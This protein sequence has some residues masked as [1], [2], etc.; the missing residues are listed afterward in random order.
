[1]PGVLM[2]M[3]RLNRPSLMVYGGTIKP[4]Q[5]GGEKLD[6]I[7]AFQAYGEYVAGTIDDKKRHDIIRNACPGPGACGGSKCLY[8]LPLYNFFLILFF[9]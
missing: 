6:I 8:F 3:G 9:C 5:C 4:G 1:M 2:A 7:S